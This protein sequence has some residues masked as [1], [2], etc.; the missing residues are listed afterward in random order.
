MDYTVCGRVVN[1]ASRLE[2]LTK[3]GEVIIDNFTRYEAQHM[4]EVETLPAVQPKGFSASEKVIPHRI[5][6]L[7]PETNRR[8]RAF[9]KRLFSYS[10][11][12]DKLMPEGL[13]E[14]DR[15]KW[16]AQHQ[17]NFEQLIDDTPVE[18]FFARANLETGQIMLPAAGGGAATPEALPPA[19]APEAEAP[20]GS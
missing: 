10:F 19:K 2:G 13:P 15:H 3:S 8:M 7:S 9:M 18:Y 6:S 11:V 1:L 5:K 4:I 14:A 17:R 20:A 12:Q 16:C